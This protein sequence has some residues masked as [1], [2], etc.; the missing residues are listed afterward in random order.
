MGSVWQRALRDDV[1]LHTG[2]VRK[3]L[4]DPKKNAHQYPIYQSLVFAADRHEQP[5]GIANILSAG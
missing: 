5:N 2:R 1:I 4:A 3:C